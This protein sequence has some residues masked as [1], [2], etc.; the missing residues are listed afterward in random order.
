TPILTGSAVA[1]ITQPV[2][3]D[4]QGNFTFPNIT[5]GRYRFS[6][7]SGAATGRG[8]AGGSIPGPPA[9]GSGPPAI[10][11]S[12]KSAAIK[13]RETLDAGL[14]IKPSETVTE[15]VLTFTSRPTMLTGALQDAR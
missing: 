10:N 9:I 15:A 2:Q 5:P 1:A 6:G 8:A 13:G 11:W 12:L 4:A 14:D 3:P 7:V